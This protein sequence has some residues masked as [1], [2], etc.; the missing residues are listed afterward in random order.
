M[1]G[2]GIDPQTFMVCATGATS[3]L[4]KTISS[5]IR[6]SCA[7]MYARSWKD[8][9]L[10]LLFVLRQHLSDCLLTVVSI[11][12]AGIAARYVSKGWIRRRC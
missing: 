4:S 12:A 11:D 9:S 10:Q 2:R 7:A 8:Q 5:F 3:A 6:R 1:C